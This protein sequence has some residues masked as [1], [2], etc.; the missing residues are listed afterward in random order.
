MDSLVNLSPAANQEALQ[1][2][3]KGNYFILLGVVSGIKPS[4]PEAFPQ[5]LV[6]LE[7]C[8]LQSNELYLDLVLNMGHIVSS[9][10]FLAPAA[11]Q[12]GH[13]FEKW[14]RGQQQLAGIRAKRPLK[15]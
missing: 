4:K 15:K 12:I 14:R 11:T 3:R 1:T 13:L 9:L 7:S 8:Y 2:I 6:L 10:N 5:Q